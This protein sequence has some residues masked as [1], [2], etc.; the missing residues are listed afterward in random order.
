MKKN[1]F[2]GEDEKLKIDMN[3]V[4]ETFKETVSS[5][6]DFEK[7][8]SLNP[9]QKQYVDMVNKLK[10]R[11]MERESEYNEN[12]GFVSVG[13]NK[14]DIEEFI[15]DPENFNKLNFT[16]TINIQN[17]DLMIGK[18]PSEK[19]YRALESLKNDTRMIEKIDFMPKDVKKN[20][21]ESL[22]SNYRQDLAEKH[23]KSIYENISTTDKQISFMYAI[24]SINLPLVEKMNPSKEDYFN[25]LK[26]SRDNFL[27]KFNEEM[28]ESGPFA[29]NR[30]FEGEEL[31]QF[32]RSTEYNFL[33]REKV[34][35]MTREVIQKYGD[36]KRIDMQPK[37]IDSVLSLKKEN[38]IS[39]EEMD[40][41]LSL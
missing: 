32:F 16:S 4:K 19:I 23:E 3:D 13:N 2:N 29:V 5:T 8:S 31:K 11:S 12:R 28:K 18:I 35:E 40:K 24:R 14:I 6:E 25:T 9:E 36:I 10:E 22:P 41:I 30:I 17:I 37:I 7:Y 38:I 27:T 21:I 34:I 1:V 26:K 20:F 15:K 39:E 33:P